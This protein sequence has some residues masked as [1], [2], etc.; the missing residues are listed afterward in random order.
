ML[1]H[2]A[3]SAKPLV[4]RGSHT[5]LM[6]SLRRT[7]LSAFATRVSVQLGSLLHE[8]LAPEHAWVWCI[9]CRN[10][11]MWQATLSLK[12]GMCIKHTR[13]V[14]ASGGATCLG[15]CFEA[16]STLSA[17]CLTLCHSAAEKIVE[18][19]HY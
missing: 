18:D 13:E 9:S 10:N 19:A 2:G 5:V 7:I 15:C 16:C 6:P 14:E 3:D 8:L 17:I 1:A 4:C 12:T 11:V